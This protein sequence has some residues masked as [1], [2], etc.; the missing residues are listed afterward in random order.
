MIIKIDEAKKFDIAS[1]RVRQ[2]RDAL[3]VES[4]WRVL[5]GRPNASVWETYRQALRD[6]PEQEGFPYT[7]TWPV[8]PE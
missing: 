6:I 3:L 4:D 5:P 1:S 7:I 8:K 2:T